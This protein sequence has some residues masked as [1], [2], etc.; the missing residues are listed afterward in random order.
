L[1]SFNRRVYSYKTDVWAFGVTLWE[2][3][4]LGD[5]P[6]GKMHCTPEFVIWL[7]DGNRLPQPQLAT[8]EM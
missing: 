2:M 8:A 7:Q 3:F 6:Y 1:E 5:N 4:A